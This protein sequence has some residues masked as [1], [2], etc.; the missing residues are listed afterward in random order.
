ML[1]SQVYEYNVDM[2]SYGGCWHDELSG[3]PD[4]D[5]LVIVAADYYFKKHPSLAGKKLTYDD[6]N[7]IIS[8]YMNQPYLKGTPVF[9]NWVRYVYSL[10]N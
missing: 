5:A 9:E 7:Y 3:F 10:N 4:K 6:V 2:L 8:P 1:I